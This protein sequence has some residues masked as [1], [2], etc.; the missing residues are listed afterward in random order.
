MIGG[1]LETALLFTGLVCTLALVLLLVVGRKGGAM[2]KPKPVIRPK[3]PAPTDNDP[4]YDRIVVVKLDQILANHH[5]ILTEVRKMSKDTDA[6]VA[7]V[8]DLRSASDAMEVLLDKIFAMIQSAP[9]LAAVR[10]AT[11]DLKAEKEEIIAATLRN[12]PAEEPP[13]EPPVE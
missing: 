4:S 6:L 9:D 2:H 1:P 12:T 5:L 7:S 11:N 3:P 8:T 10:K 13:V